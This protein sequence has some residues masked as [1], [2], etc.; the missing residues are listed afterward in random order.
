MAD[1]EYRVLPA[2]EK[3]RKMPGVKGNGERFAR[4]LQELMNEMGA[5]GWEYQ[6]ADILPCSER[7]G[8][9]GSHTVYRSVLVFRRPRDAQGGPAV[10]LPGATAEHDP[11]VPPLEVP[12][13]DPS[14]T[15]SAPRAEPLTSTAT[16]DAPQ[17]AGDTTPETGDTAADAGDNAPDAGDETAE[18]PSGEDPSR[19]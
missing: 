9:T 11:A 16:Q 18:T 3:P 12:P 4:S 14:Q 8:I 10:T 19:G 17:D 1:Y 7:H 2:P 6:R 13:P 5:D 15:E